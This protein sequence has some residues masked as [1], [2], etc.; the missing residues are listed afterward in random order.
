M[1]MIDY[2]FLAIA[3]PAIVIIGNTSKYF[4]RDFN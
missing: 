4:K 1:S 2:I 3:L